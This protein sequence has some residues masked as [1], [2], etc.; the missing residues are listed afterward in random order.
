MDHPYET[1]LERHI[2]HDVDSGEWETFRALSQHFELHANALLRVLIRNFIYRH[3]HVLEAEDDWMT[4][5][6]EEEPRTVRVDQQ[7]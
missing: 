1:G 3:Q 5:Y 7:P 6:D 4:F 2:A